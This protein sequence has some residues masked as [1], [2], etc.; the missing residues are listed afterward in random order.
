[1]THPAA[2][3]ACTFTSLYLMVKLLLMLHRCVCALRYMA[4]RILTDPAPQL[5]QSY[6]YTLSQDSPQLPSSSCL[7]GSWY[8]SERLGTECQRHWDAN[9]QALTRGDAAG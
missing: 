2:V 4:R 1:M 3:N 9:V 6:I 5:R 7:L 8:R